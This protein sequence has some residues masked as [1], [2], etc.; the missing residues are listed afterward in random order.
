MRCVGGKPGEVTRKIDRSQTHLTH[1]CTIGLEHDKIPPIA[2]KLFV[3]EVS[4]FTRSQFAITTG[5]Q[6]E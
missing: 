2:G 5:D 3:L 4:I 6:I 1:I